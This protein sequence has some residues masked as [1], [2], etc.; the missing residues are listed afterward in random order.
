VSAPLELHVASPRGFA[1]LLARELAAFGAQDLKERSTGVACRGDLSVAYRACLESRIANRV[2]LELG[3]FEAADTDAFYA[4]ARSID[5]TQHLGPESTLA[6]NFSGRHPT[7]THSQFGALR[8]KDA[9]VD[10]LREASGSRPDVARER[11]DVRVHAHAQ[12]PR[13][14]VSLDL[15]GESLHRR[16]YREAAGEAPVKENVAAGVLVRAGWPELAAQ[17]AELLDPLCGSGTFLIEGALIAADIAPGLMR[18]YFGFSGWRGHDAALWESLRS[19]ARERARVGVERVRFVARGVDRDAA[20]IANARR[21]AHSAGLESLVRFEVGALADSAPLGGGT[22]LVCTNP[23][24]GIRLEDRDS[25]RNAHRELGRV[26]RERFLG[27]K[28]AVLTG[29]ADLGLEIGIRAQRVH[30][31]WNGPIECRLLRIDVRADEFRVPGVPSRETKID[32]SLRET[33]GAKMVANRIRKN[34]DRLSEWARREGVSCYR[35]YD[36]DM[37]EY[38]LAIDR[39]LCIEPSDE[40]LYVQEYQA[41]RE[42]EE[43]AVRRRRNEALAVLPDVTGVPVERIRFRTRRKHS[44]GSQYEK[45]ATEGQFRVVEEGGLRFWVNFEDYLDTGLFLDHRLTR[46]RLRAAA[47]RRRFLNL[48]CYTGTA[49]VYAAAG[50]ARSTTSVD[51]SATYLDWAQRN[52]TLNG[53]SG[54]DHELVRADAREWLADAARRNA[55]YELVFLDPPTFSTSKRMEGTLD[56]QRD[57][58]HLVDACMHLLAKDGLLVFSTNAQRFKIDAVLAERYVVEDVSAATLPHDFA[59]NPRIHR[60]YEIRHAA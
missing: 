43:E 11:P 29:A 8:L 59:R 52:L 42:I 31:V 17:G 25:A 60:C 45:R 4:A 6:C 23:P 2:F 14:T 41:P 56:V 54:R 28:A 48:F 13:I 16:G 26:L 32:T 30:T 15:S 55:R 50:R 37:P 1:D 53:L 3:R 20:A 9:I 47:Q 49:T 27:W 58:S 5:W 22:G 12:G 46:A 24:Y 18:D 10:S 57:H 51:L 36:A 40:W 7:I 39:Y 21:N 35:L 34:L 44:R 33:P 38:S 19:A